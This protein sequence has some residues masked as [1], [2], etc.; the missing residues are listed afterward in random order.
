MGEG[1]TNLSLILSINYTQQNKILTNNS[2]PLIQQ[3]ILTIILPMRLLPRVET[4]MVS[5]INP[6]IPQN[7]HKIQFNF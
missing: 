1:F 6:T 5:H 4:R 7:F 2:I 3:V